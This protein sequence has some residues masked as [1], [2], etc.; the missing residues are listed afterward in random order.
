MV[1]LAVLVD[2]Y[3]IRT[4]PRACIREPQRRNWK[5]LPSMNALENRIIYYDSHLV[6]RA[7]FLQ[8]SRR[9]S[10]LKIVSLHQVRLPGLPGYALEVYLQSITCQKG[11]IQLGKAD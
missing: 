5:I 11:M 10:Y 4:G 7:I 3:I 8:S 9:E 1:V 2:A 6:C